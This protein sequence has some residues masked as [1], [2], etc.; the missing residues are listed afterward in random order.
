MKTDVSETIR[1]PCHDG[2]VLAGRFWPAQQ[3]R[4]LGTVIINAA[5]GVLQNYYHHYARFLTG[6]GFAAVTY[7]YRGI[8][9][10]RPKNM[11]D[12]RFCWR[13]WGELD[14]AA[15]V[16]WSRKH[17]PHGLLAVVGHSIGGFLPGFAPNADSVDRILAVGAQYAYWR[18]YAAERRK[19]LFVKWHLFMPAITAML[20]YFPG[21]RLGW[22]EDLPAGVANEWSFRRARLESSYPAAERNAILACFAK[23]RAPILSI[24]TTDDEYAT[25]QAI[26]RG[27]KY[28]VNSDRKYVL[29]KPADLNLNTLGHFS[30]FHP[31]HHA[32]FW[33]KT[34]IWLKDGVSPWVPT[35]S[36]L[37]RSR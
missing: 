23:V 29:L 6:Y 37:P 35:E 9:M 2:Y 13:D 26:R 16:K 10:S 8:G 32:L 19:K 17:D 5:T 21:R 31:R 28:Y 30:L 7:D 33:P 1:I 22:L 12:A 27:L 15:V 11:R 14:F 24:G 3:D 20:G 36:L 4:M 18:D 25:P 34:V